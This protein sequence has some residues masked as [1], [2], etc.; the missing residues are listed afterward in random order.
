MNLIP[1]IASS[2]VQ[3]GN[4]REK[5][6][7]FVKM[8][9]LIEAK[10][11]YLVNKHRKLCRLT[12]QNAFL[13]EVR[14]DYTKY[15]RHMVEQREQQKKALEILDA[16]LR[17]LTE[18]GELSENNIKDAKEEQAKILREL[19]KVK[20]KLTTLIKDTRLIR[21]HISKDNHPSSQLAINNP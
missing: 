16:Y 21:N 7:H 14:K 11:E 13:N 8:Q 4:F 1:P 19:D 3:H 18:S 9:E 17:E 10:E 5:D 15:Y 20:G 12:K 6:D 2:L